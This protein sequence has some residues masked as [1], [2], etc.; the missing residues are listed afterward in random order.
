MPLRVRDDRDHPGVE[1]LHQDLVGVRK[2]G[3]VRELDE[4]VTLVVDGVLGGMVKR[5]LDGVNWSRK[6]QPR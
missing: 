3:E 1:Q 2:H 4:Q 6:S 5:V